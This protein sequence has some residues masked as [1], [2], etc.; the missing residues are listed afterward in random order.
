MNWF[1]LRNFELAFYLF[2]IDMNIFAPTKFG[3]F[4]FK[5]AWPMHE[6]NSFHVLSEQPCMISRKKNLIDLICILS[7]G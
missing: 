6:P 1:G 5:F 7:K 4:S 3:L 2:L